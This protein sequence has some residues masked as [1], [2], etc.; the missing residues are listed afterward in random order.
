MS[1]TFNILID[2]DNLN[3]KEKNKG[4][5]YISKLIYNTVPKKIINNYKRIKLRFYGGWFDK[6]KRTERA[7]SLYEEIHKMNPFKYNNS[8]LIRELA[9][10]ILIKSDFNLLRTYRP[11]GYP[12]YLSCKNPT[13]LGCNNPERWMPR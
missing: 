13:D 9:L 12:K 6:K 1:K 5:D 2:Y 10:S 7:K 11:Q 8:I 4:L 3:R